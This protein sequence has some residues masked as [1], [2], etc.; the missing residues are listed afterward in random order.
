MEDLLE[1][2]KSH[3]GPTQTE[4]TVNMFKQLIA[5]GHDL[6]GDMLF[7]FYKEKAKQFMDEGHELTGDTLYLVNFYKERGLV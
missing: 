2:V 6:T 7:E 1:F 4:I 3:K 5:D